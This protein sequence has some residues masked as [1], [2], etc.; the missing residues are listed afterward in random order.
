ML[1]WGKSALSALMVAGLAATAGAQQKGCEIDENS[2]QQVTRAVLFLMSAQSKPADAAKS[3]RDA[4]K[5]L[6]EGDKTRNP[7][8]RSWTYGRTLVAF[9]SQP[10]FESGFASR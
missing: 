3:L 7:V 4:V 9:M 2:P 10:G 1:V 8:G 6:N 5:L